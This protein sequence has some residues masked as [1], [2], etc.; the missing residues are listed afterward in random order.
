MNLLALIQRLRTQNAFVMLAL[1]LAAQFGTRGRRYVGAELLPERFVTQNAYREYGIR[2][3]TIIANDGT[4]YSP[5]QKKG[6][7]LV[8]D[9]LVELGNSDIGREMN[10]QDYDALI[11]AL[12]RNADMDATQRLLNWSDVTLNRALIE[13]NERQRWMAIC[14]ARIVRRGDNEYYEEVVLPNP[15]GHRVNAAG[16]WT[17]DTYDPY[18]SDILPMAN[19]LRSKGYE[20]NRIIT[21]NTVIAMMAGNAKI[22]ARTG[23]LVAQVGGAISVMRASADREAIGR[24]FQRDGL[25]A[26]ETYDLQY[27]VQGGTGFFLPRNVFV[28][29]CTTGRDERIDLGLD[30]P[31]VRQD[32]LG[33]VGVGRAAGQPRPGR[34]VQVEPFFNKPPRVEG[35]GWQTSLAVITEPEAVGVIKAIS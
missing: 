34:V 5:V 3:R 10:A 9:F 11:E 31:L 20:I 26:P 28:M 30:T 16:M 15:T 19:L 12:G 21:S 32:T 7:E 29:V 14:D 35:E 24:M 6:G 25:P 4:R 8:G 33:Y 22:Q 17:D 18:E 13:H 27:G 1:S 2:Y 23:S